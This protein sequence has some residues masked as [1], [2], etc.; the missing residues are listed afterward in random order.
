MN[1]Q[2]HDLIMLTSVS[3]ACEQLTDSELNS[4]YMCAL[5][6]TDPEEVQGYDR[7]KS[8]FTDKGRTRMHPATVDALAIIWRRR[9]V[10]G[11]QP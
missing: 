4:I 9:C 7:V 6:D 8:L 1:E 11:V 2:Q 10:E 3:I 5:L